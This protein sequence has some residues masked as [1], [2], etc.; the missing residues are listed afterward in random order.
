MRAWKYEMRSKR[1]QRKGKGV[2]LLLE[3]GKGYDGTISL[4]KGI[5]GL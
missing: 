4:M 2:D 5:L 1:W 3:K